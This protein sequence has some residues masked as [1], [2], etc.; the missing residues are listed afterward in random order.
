MEKLK[1]IVLVIKVWKLV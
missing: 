1:E